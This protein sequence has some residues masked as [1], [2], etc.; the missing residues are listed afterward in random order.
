[1]MLPNADAAVISG[2][3]IVDHLLN[4]SHPDGAAKA[5]F[6]AG[7]GFSPKEWTTLAETLHR[8][9][10]TAQVAN[11]VESEHG[12]KYIIEGSII[13]P[14]GRTVPIRTDWIVDAGE[15]VARLVTAYPL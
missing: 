4:P 13:G 3:K 1:M 14:L 2:A 5:R 12:T 7:L 8:L 15:T 9:A 10:K 11:V 6:F